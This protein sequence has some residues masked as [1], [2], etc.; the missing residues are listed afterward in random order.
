[1]TDGR[2]SPAAP[3]RH[4]AARPAWRCRVCAAPWPC[5]PAKLQ[6]RREY[7][8]DRAALA[9]Y[10][11]LLMHDAIADELRLRAADVDPAAYFVRFIGW[12]RP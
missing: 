9:I 2:I 10:L 1:M 5:Q 11:C 6:L 12:T 7:A 3:N 8:D 4:T